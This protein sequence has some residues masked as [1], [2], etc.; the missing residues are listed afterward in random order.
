[1][2]RCYGRSARPPTRFRSAGSR[3]S[4]PSSRSCSGASSA[5][6][7]SGPHTP[8]APQVVAEALGHRPDPLDLGRVHR[9]VLPGRPGE[10][11]AV[12]DEVE[13]EELV[14]RGPDGG[15]PERSVV[16]VAGERRVVEHRLDVGPGRRERPERVV[17]DGRRRARACRSSGRE[18]HAVDVDDVGDDAAGVPLLARRR[19]RPAR[20]ARRRRSWPGRR[21][22]ACGSGRRSRSCRSIVV[23]AAPAAVLY[24]SAIVTPPDLSFG[25]GPS[26]RSGG[27]NRRSP[28]VTATDVRGRAATSSPRGHAGDRPAVLGHVRLVGVA[29]D[30]GE[31]GDPEVVA[32]GRRGGRSAARGRC[33]RRTP[34]RSRRRGRSAGAAGGSTPRSAPASPS[35][36]YAGSAATRRGQLDG[37]VGRL[38]V[39]AAGGRA[40]RARPGG[41]R[42][43]RRRRGARRGPGHAVHRAGRRARPARRC[44]STAS[45]WNTPA[46]APGG[47]GRRRPACPAAARTTRRGCPARRGRRRAPRSTTGP[48]TRQGSDRGARRPSRRTGRPARTCRSGGG[49]NGSNQRTL[50]GS[51][52][53]ANA[54][55]AATL[56]GVE[57]VVHVE[58]SRRWRRPGRRWWRRTRRSPAAACPSA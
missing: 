8:G 50:G 48:C 24:R 40:P 15:A 36:P 17:G 21:R 18:H 54:S 7:T 16:L 12:D 44:S 27:R 53:H 25:I 41:R 39:R 52:G 33:G 29:G 30:R 19:V 58:G 51:Q 9:L 49:A 57:R 4:R 22:R 11:P 28:S 10:V 56:L 5:T 55:T 6:A 43:R 20:R 2:A 42:D 46:A 34:V 23:R 31:L 37:V 3:P 26:G 14:D 47:S 32:N 35:T 1:M 38:G 45:T 13:P